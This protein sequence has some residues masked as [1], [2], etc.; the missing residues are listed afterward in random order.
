MAQ[1]PFGKLMPPLPASQAGAADAGALASAEIA[2]AEQV[3]QNFVMS[4][5][6]KA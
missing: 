6:P 4:F 3:N 5:L 1:N 2:R